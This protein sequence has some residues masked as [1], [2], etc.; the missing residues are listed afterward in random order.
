MCIGVPIAIE[1]AGAFTVVERQSECGSKLPECAST[2]H[3]HRRVLA[4]VHSVFFTI[5]FV[6]VS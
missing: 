3:E 2:S 1:D 6:S 4:A 5:S